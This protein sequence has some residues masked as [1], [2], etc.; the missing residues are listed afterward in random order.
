MNEELQNA[1][2]AGKLNLQAAEALEKLAPGAFCQHKS[3]GFGQVA[4]WNLLTGQIIID[5]QSKKGHPMQAQYAAETLAPIHD[6]HILAR[7]ASDAAA[8]KS[9]AT[10]DPLGFM[11]DVLSDHGGK[12]T[13]EQ[14]A[15]SLTPEVFDA[16]GFKRWW[17]GTKKK[18]KS[19]GHFQIPAKKTEPI[20]LLESPVDPGKGLV[21]S[22]RA[23]RHLKD[24]ITAL[25]QLTKALDDLSHETEALE[26]L[27]NQ[28]NDAANKARRLQ[29]TQALELLLGRDEIVARYSTIPRAETTL[30]VADIL[31]SEQARLSELFTGLASA[32][33][34]RTLEQFPTA[35]DERWTEVAFRLMQQSP[36]R[37]VVEISRLVEKEGKVEDLRSALARCISDRSITSEMLI[38]LCKERGASFPEL[39]GPDLLGS[40]LSSLERD[41]LAEK[42]GSRLQDLLF[43]D[44]ELIAELLADAEPDQVRDAMRRMLLTPVFEDLSKRS[45]LARIVKIHPELQS[46]ITGGGGEKEETITVSWASLEKRKAEF[47]DIVTRQIPENLRDIAV[48]KEEGDLRENFG[49]KAAKEQQR[50]LQRRRA[51]TERDLALARGTN[52]ENPD[53]TQVSIGT[54]VTLETPSGGT[55]VYSILGAWDSAPAMGIVSYKAAIGQALLGKKVGDSID[56]PTEGGV[57]AVT[58]K[59]IE[60]FTNLAILSEKIHILNTPALS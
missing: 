5:F 1:V 15:S 45:L 25:D 44:R 29:P 48:A 16:A 31:R 2:D 24:Q 54:T 35:F 4:E 32:K 59:K 52:F 14:L 21:D 28:I 50:V 9:H 39:F 6:K 8:V 46:M 41:Q 30:T 26:A 20:V 40:V 10:E 36:S 23:A 57:H 22:F 42:R 18:L 49:F 56:L 53:T 27:V 47:E 34:R 58:V 19:D 51:E 7:K 17:D 55:E 43:E 37:L 38:W 11:R 13:V 3:W 60:P 33:Q 12:M